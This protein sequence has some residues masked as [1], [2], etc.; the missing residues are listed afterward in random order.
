MMVAVA[1]RVYDYN[2]GRPIQGA[3]VSLGGVSAVTGADGVAVLDVPAGGLTLRVSKSGY[4][5][6][7]HFVTISTASRVEVPLIPAMRLL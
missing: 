6:V 7:E 3:L 5:M 2:T 4:R 1:V